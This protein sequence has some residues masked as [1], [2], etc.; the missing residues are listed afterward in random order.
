MLLQ[1]LGDGVLFLVPHPGVFQVLHGLLRRVRLVEFHQILENLHSLH[2]SERL[3]QSL[4]G[5]HREQGLVAHPRH[6]LPRCSQ[7][8]RVGQVTA[9]FRRRERQFAGEVVV[10]NFRGILT[11]YVH[12]SQG[13][14][15]SELVALGEHGL[16]RVLDRNLFLLS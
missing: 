8:E 4:V 10:E 15:G 6:D 7:D 11:I 5:A 2:L 14:P 1:E 13:E 16:L 3:P 12:L 9:A